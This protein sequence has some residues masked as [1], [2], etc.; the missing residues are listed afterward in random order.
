MWTV[1]VSILT[2]EDEQSDNE[3]DLE[4][5]EVELSLTKPPNS[6]NILEGVSALRAHADIY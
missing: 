2:C 3:K 1:G 5:G 4:K 6:P